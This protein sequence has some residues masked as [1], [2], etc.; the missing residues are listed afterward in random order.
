MEKKQKQ[1]KIPALVAHRGYAASYPEN[2]LLAFTEALKAGARFIEFDVQLCADGTPFVIHDH[3]LYRTCGL[4]KELFTLTAK[5]VKKVQAHEPARFGQKFQNQNIGIPA[6]SEVIDLLRNW[7]EA[8]AFVELKRESLKRHGL[9][10][11]VEKVMQVCEPVLEQC[12]LISKSIPAI[13]YARSRRAKSIGWVVTEWTKDSQ[14]QMTALAPDVL[15]CNHEKIPS[16][17]TQLWP[18][19]WQWAFYEVIDPKLARRLYAQG[20]AM[21]ETKDIGKMLASLQPDEKTSNGSQ[22]KERT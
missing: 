16:P 19:P 22:T 6:L 12:C 17:T 13:V 9:E 10:T 21:I 1:K 5:A 4:N 2:T 20:A 15:F 18:G 8:T 14:K 7:P 3:R 11:M